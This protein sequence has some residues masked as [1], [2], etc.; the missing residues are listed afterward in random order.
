MKIN[1]LVLFDQVELLEFRPEKCLDIT[2]DS[3]DFKY[4]K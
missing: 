2:T 1:D 3:V 4:F